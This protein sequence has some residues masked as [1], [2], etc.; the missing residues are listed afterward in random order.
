VIRNFAITNTYQ[1]TFLHH[2]LTT[3]QWSLKNGRSSKDLG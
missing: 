3:F 2:Q 1:A